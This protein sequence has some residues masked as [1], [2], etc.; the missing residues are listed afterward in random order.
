MMDHLNQQLRLNSD[1]QTRAIERRDSITGLLA[2]AAVVAP[3][4]AC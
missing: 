2:E 1:N 4:R 3:V